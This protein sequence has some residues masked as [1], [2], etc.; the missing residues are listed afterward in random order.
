MPRRSLGAT[1]REGSRTEVFSVRFILEKGARGL[2]PGT[3]FDIAETELGSPAFAVPEGWVYSP[4]YIEVEGIPK[5]SASLRAVKNNKVVFE[6]RGFEINK[7]AEREGGLVEVA[8]APVLGPGDTFGIYLQ[9]KEP[10]RTRCIE[11]VLVH[12]SIT[13]E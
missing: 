7:I 3:I 13:P 10:V 9:I 4:K 1:P 6:G 11:E 12:M 8:S 5:L 2:V